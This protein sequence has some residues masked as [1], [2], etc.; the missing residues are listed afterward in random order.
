MNALRAL[1][2]GLALTLTSALPALAQASPPD[3]S[4]IPGIYDDAD[5]DDVVTQVVSGTGSVTPG[6]VDVLRFVPRPAESLGQPVETAP[7]SLATDAGP[8]RAPPS[9]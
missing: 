6:L 8:E 9:S 4:W 1:V 3:P 2:V 7:D 5:F